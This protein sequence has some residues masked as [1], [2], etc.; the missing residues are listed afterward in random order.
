MEI[1]TTLYQNGQIWLAKISKDIVELNNT[2]DQLDITDIYKLFIFS[3]SHG[4][5]TK[6][7]CSEP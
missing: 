2:I 6:I 5:F 4:I 7:D 1:S 3:R